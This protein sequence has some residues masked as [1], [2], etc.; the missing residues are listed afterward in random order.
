M[1]KE[2]MK[3]ALNEIQNT[4]PFNNF[5]GELAYR[6]ISFTEALGG[7]CVVQSEK[8]VMA[9]RSRRSRGEFCKV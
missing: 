9:L 7:N 4:V 6:G 3:E 5:T 8:L 2:L 1:S